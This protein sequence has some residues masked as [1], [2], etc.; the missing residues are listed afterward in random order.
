[1]APGRELDQYAKAR[2]LCRLCGQTQT[3]KRAGRFLKKM[4]NSWAPLTVRDKATGDYQV[5][6]G[7][8]IQ[9]TCYSL[10]QARRKLGEISS[11]RGSGEHSLAGGSL[12]SR[13]SSLS[14]RSSRLPSHPASPLRP[15]SSTK[16]SRMSSSS[17]YSTMSNTSN[18]NMSDDD[19][20]LEHSQ[21]SALTG[22]TSEGQSLPR[23]PLAI[24][25]KSPHGGGPA[26]PIKQLLEQFVENRKEHILNL[27]TVEL[28]ELNIGSVLTTLRSKKLSIPNL[29]LEALH[30]DKC[31]LNNGR[32]ERFFEGLLQEGVEVGKLTLRSNNLEKIPGLNHYL[33]DTKHLVEL[34]L[35][36]NR[37]GD[38]GATAVI[39][40]LAKNPND[41]LVKLNL[42]RNQIWT[43]SE[44]ARG[45][46]TASPTLTSLNLENNFLRDAGVG[47]LATAIASNQESTIQ[48]LFLGNNAFAFYGTEA[49]SEMIFTNKCL[50][51][52]GI[53]G[54]EIGEKG[55][56]SFLKCLET[57]KTL[58]ELSGLYANRIANTKLIHA[59]EKCLEERAQSKLSRAFSRRVSSRK[60]SWNSANNNSMTDIT[61]SPESEHIL[62]ESRHKGDK[63]D[64]DLSSSQLHGDSDTLS[65]SSGFAGFDDGDSTSTEGFS[66]DDDEDYGIELNSILPLPTI[67]AATSTATG[68]KRANSYRGAIEALDLA[69]SQHHRLVE[70]SEQGVGGM[71]TICMSATGAEE[72]G[73]EAIAF[74]TRKD[75]SPEAPSPRRGK[76]EKAPSPFVNADD[77]EIEVSVGPFAAPFDV[78]HLAGKGKLPKP[79]TRFALEN[80]ISGCKAGLS[81]LEKENDPDSKKKRIRLRKRLVKLVPMRRSMPSRQELEQKLAEIDMAMANAKRSLDKKL[82]ARLEK[83]RD[84][85]KAMLE[86]E[87]EAENNCQTSL[88]QG[89]GITG[90]T[91]STDQLQ[92]TKPRTADPL[93]RHVKKLSSGS[94]P[95]LMISGDTVDRLT[96]F[97]AAPLSYVD[98]KTNE[99]HQLPLL[100]FDYE[101][102]ILKE[103]LK[104]AE[105]IGARVEI[106]H[107]IATTDRLSAF[108]AQGGRRLLHLS[109]HGH[110]DWLALENGFGDM[111]PL[112]VDDLRR[113]IEAG[114]T[115]LDFVFISACH[116]LP[117]GSAFL[118]AGVP[119]VVCARQDAKFRD[120]A[121]A[122]FSRSFYRALACN[123]TLKQAFRMA[124]ETVRVSPLVKDAK[125][126]SDKFVLLPAKED[127]DPY[128]DVHIFFKDIRSKPIDKRKPKPQPR[129]ILQRV[130]LSFIGRETEMYRILEAL[131]CTDLV[132]VCGGKGTGK[133]TL[134]A[135]VAKY[136]QQRQKS[137]LFEDV[138]WLPNDAVGENDKVVTMFDK[139]LTLLTEQKGFVKN[140]AVYKECRGKIIQEV[141]GQRLL[142]VVDGR[143]FTSA[144]SL[145]NLEQFLK[146]MLQSLSI[147]VVVIGNAGLKASRVP[148]RTVEIGPLDFETSAFLFSRL[149][150]SG[151]F[152]APE[153]AK[154]LSPKVNKVSAYPLKRNT[155][156]FEKI[157]RGFPADIEQA[158]VDMN[159][160]DLLELVRIAQRPCPQVS[161]RAGLEDEIQKKLSEEA[162]ALRRK[163]Y[164][165]AR[166][167]RDL[168]DELQGLRQYLKSIE[169]L[170]VE[171]ASLRERL[172]KATKSR[173]Y[174]SANTIQ[175][176]LDAIEKQLEKENQWK[177]Q[178]NED[179][180][181]KITV[182]ARD[183]RR[184]LKNDR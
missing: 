164:L 124:K 98:H 120:E 3:H 88:P 118:K 80:E 152:S 12:A 52:I 1:M 145:R 150:H 173:N 47:M 17:D 121:C 22:V 115:S 165:R 175:K 53:T 81:S 167:L 7:F 137:F 181:E 97:Q 132:Q 129:R 180:F 16:N 27:S 122:E 144:S 108:F 21:V 8:C 50:V 63:G 127:E 4:R 65:T 95:G 113:F 5:Y 58:R 157:G 116:S 130:P 182:R 133:A 74:P 90:T 174:D 24:H 110:P 39:N 78:E 104:D 9:P 56:K 155:L 46:L 166:D 64:D 172:E 99:R 60:A 117:S 103:A 92:P 94:I 111:Q 42:A 135:A 55:A 54:N 35:S 26:L 184:K 19:S 68:L 136:I 146:D 161:T 32:L 178:W 67:H 138:I 123:K 140:T 176:R 139:M 170:T 131:R 158:A 57:N 44:S 36:K 38:N 100:D 105:N 168:I 96:L 83:E 183:M 76:K 134:V 148:S 126:E 18:S 51:T 77:F 119:H 79:T 20:Y 112:F 61:F 142:L 109:C 114:G 163:H 177:D 101:S 59:I 25:A 106:E 82:K 91:V 43:L 40:A 128:H 85:N 87:I 84:S 159:E 86:K 160:K 179:R 2:G 72:D 147:K 49:L 141:N 125:L 143:N 33:R 66:T 89:A 23:V 62:A 107:E 11:R 153:L 14:H 151:R 34:N 10:D 93:P 48:K 31:K 30:A 70:G 15:P 162:I 75:P 41:C 169:E 102:R 71:K 6:K 13:R 28:Y 171:L 45:F 154:I 73:F 29:R 69:S 156:I 149:V 37:L